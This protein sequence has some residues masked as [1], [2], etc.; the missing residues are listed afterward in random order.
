MKTFIL[1]RFG[2]KMI[3][4]I[5]GS[6]LAPLVAW[7]A[8]KYLPMD[9]ATQGHVVEVAISAIA[10]IIGGHNAAQGYA[11]GKTGGATSSTT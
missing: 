8:I 6:L 4:S 7:V 10:F 2:K 3:A 11:D 1:Q 5:L 9:A